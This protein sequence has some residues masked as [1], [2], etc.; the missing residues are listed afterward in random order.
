MKTLREMQITSIEK[1]G[2]IE[3]VD[4]RDSGD[5]TSLL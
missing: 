1:T 4:E 5:D 3:E 2:A